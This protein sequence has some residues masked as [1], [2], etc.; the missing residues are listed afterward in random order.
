[1][2]TKLEISKSLNTMRHL[3][4]SPITDMNVA[5]IVEQ[6]HYDLCDV[7]SDILDAAV[8]H[9]RTS[10]NPY[11]PTSGQLREKA[12]DLILLAMGVPTAGE[13]WVQVNNS[14]VHRETVVCEI[15]D[16]LRKDA[17]SGIGYW[18]AVF[19]LRDHENKCPLCQPGGIVEQ[20][21]H[22]VVARIVDRLGGRDRILTGE[23][24]ADRSQFIRAYNE[25]VVSETKKMSLPTQ[26]KETIGAIA[27][28]QVALL[29]SGLSGAMA[30]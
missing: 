12:M 4:K 25:I 18:S 15:G 10:A 1:M 11:F 9:Y 2:A 7:Q 24:V 14:L 16:R 13:A 5:E 21:S 20:Y 19:A 8:V 17:E 3:P 29:V 30:K 27:S 23:A 6:Y 28:G 26:V 22:P